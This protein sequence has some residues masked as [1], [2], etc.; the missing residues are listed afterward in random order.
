MEHYEYMDTIMDEVRGGLE[1]WE[2]D[3]PDDEEWPEDLWS[4]Y[5]PEIEDPE[6]DGICDLCPHG[7][8]CINS[9]FSEPYFNEDMGFDPY[10]GCYTDDC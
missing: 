3:M 1:P 5:D 7:D 6:C 9:H 2:I 4:D 8:E 10:L